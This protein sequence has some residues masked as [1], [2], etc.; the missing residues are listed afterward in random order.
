MQEN[1]LGRKGI[2]DT[3]RA[4]AL[5]AVAAARQV[6]RVALLLTTIDSPAEIDVKSVGRLLL[7]QPAAREGWRGS[8]RR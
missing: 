8:G 3:V 1:I 4:E 2:N 5:A 6:D 7:A